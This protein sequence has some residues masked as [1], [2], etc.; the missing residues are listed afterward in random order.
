[1]VRLAGV[2]V[3]VALCAA[4]TLRLS[5]GVPASTPAAVIATPAH[6]A[7]SAS[8]PRLSPNDTIKEFCTGCHNQ[9]DL[10]GELDLENFDVAKAADHAATGG[11]DDPQAARRA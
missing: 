4:L 1:M 2:S 11:E 6:A 5:A 10:K 8:A 3:A 7:A 9:Y